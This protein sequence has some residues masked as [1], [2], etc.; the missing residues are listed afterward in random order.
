MVLKLRC[1]FS[2]KCWWLIT[3]VYANITLHKKE[4]V[5]FPWKWTFLLR[6]IWRAVCGTEILRWN[7][8]IVFQQ[9]SSANWTSIDSS[10][11]P[12]HSL[13]QTREEIIL[14][15]SKVLIWRVLM[16]KVRGYGHSRN[17][18]R[19]WP[20]KFPAVEALWPWCS[21]LPPPGSTRL[22]SRDQLLSCRERTRC[23]D[24]SLREPYPS[25]PFPSKHEESWARVPENLLTGQLK[26]YLKHIL[27]QLQQGFTDTDHLSVKK[28][29]QKTS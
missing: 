9:Y 20:L 21:R 2:S 18:A 28:H 26:N 16:D 24:T 27:M 23:N 3:T 22:P 8:D 4:I 5:H 17:L 14:R 15:I 7:W 10:C 29:T 1:C 6:K 11:V 12:T 13:F 19:V 25:V